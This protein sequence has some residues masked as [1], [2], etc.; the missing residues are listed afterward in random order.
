[1]ITDS[2]ALER[3]NRD[4][5]AAQPQDILAWAWERFGPKIAATSSFQSQSL[6]LLHMIARTAPQLPVFFLDT[7]FHFPETLA[8]RDR[9]MRDLGLNVVVLAPEIG[10]DGFRRLHGDLYRSNP[11]LC[12]FINK[13]EPLERAMEALDAWISG[14]R[15]DQTAR[16]SDTPIVSRQPD[17]RIKVCPLATWTRREVWQYISEHDLPR[18]PL[19]SQGYLSIGCAPCTRPV[20]ANEDERSGRWAGQDKTECGLHTILGSAS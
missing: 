2:E 8:F 13:V 17:G 9:L 14:I 11:D 6:P 20:G 12:C 5:E 19:L 10:H 16:R 3:I 4:F 7:G 18:H 15:R 1:M